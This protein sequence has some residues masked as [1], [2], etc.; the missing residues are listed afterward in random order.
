VNL[1]AYGL[2]WAGVAV[3]AF[4]AIRLCLSGE[5]FAR[6]HFVG[7]FTVIAAPL[8]LLGLAFAQG[9][10]TSFHDIIKLALIG[11]LL[12][13]TGPASVV[14]TARAAHGP[15]TSERADG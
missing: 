1:L 12:V 4:S 13:L 3:A 15:A 14:A 6:L 2:A 9:L 8:V 7:P 10:W 11:V 5:V